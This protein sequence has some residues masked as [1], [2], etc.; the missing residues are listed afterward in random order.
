MST[1]LT[2]TPFDSSV[3]GNDS[4]RAAAATVA[5]P[6]LF[7]PGQVVATPGAL[8]ALEANRCLP[9]DLLQRHLTG[10]YGVLDPSDLEANRQALFLGTRILSSYPQADGCLIWLITE[11][12]R[13][14]TTFLLPEEY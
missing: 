1:T 11:A 5:K 12:D 2:N 6:V 9:L 8:A 3:D 14:V 10:D 13:S 4:F 7:C